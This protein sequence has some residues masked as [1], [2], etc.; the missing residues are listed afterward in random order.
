M[1]EQLV[2]EIGSTG[3]DVERQI[4]EAMGRVNQAVDAGTVPVGVRLCVG[5]GV[6]ESALSD[7]PAKAR[8][9]MSYRLIAA[10]LG[11]E[12]MASEAGVDIQAM[13]AAQGD[14]LAA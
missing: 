3:A 14:S 10:L 12:P 13:A 9:E 6:L 1:F 7:M 2:G 11:A 8:E 4:A 5:L